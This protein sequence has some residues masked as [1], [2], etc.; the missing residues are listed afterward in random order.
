MFE[1]ET[2]V[3]VMDV[4]VTKQSSE[5]LV[6]ISVGVLCCVVAD[7]E[8]LTRLVCTSDLIVIGSL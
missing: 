3:K 5:N 4:V 8:G 2:K 6:V 7:G 1:S